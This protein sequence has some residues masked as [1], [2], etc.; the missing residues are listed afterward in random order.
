MIGVE[1][2]LT[3]LRKTFGP[4]VTLVAASIA[5]APILF[6]ACGTPANTASPSTSSSGSSGSPADVAPCESL[7]STSDAAQLTGASTMQIDQGTYAY[8]PADTP[9]TSCNY[10]ANM[11]PSGG[12]VVGVP[13]GSKSFQLQLWTNQQ[14]GGNTYSNIMNNDTNPYHN[15]P[16]P[17][18]PQ[19]VPI[20]GMGTQA[21]WYGG[22][23]RFLLVQVDSTIVFALSGYPLSETAAIDEGQKLVSELTGSSSGSSTTVPS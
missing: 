18:N 16:N 14:D 19:P 7:L 12:G 15:S 6:A 22:Y 3:K 17:Y 11:T 9:T 21:V 23:A 20:Q 1:N 4:R 13:D 10:N 8:I 5:L 2:H